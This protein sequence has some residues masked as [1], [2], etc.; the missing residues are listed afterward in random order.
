MDRHLL[1]LSYLWCFVWSACQSTQTYA[2]HD[3]WI[4]KLPNAFSSNAHVQK[5][6][7]FF[8][9]IGTTYDTKIGSVILANV[10]GSANVSANVPRNFTWADGSTNVPSDTFPRGMRC[11]IIHASMA[12]KK[13]TKQLINHRVEHFERTKKGNH[14]PMFWIPKQNTTLSGSATAVPLSNNA[15][16]IGGSVAFPFCVFSW[17]RYFVC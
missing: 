1:S 13:Q 15:P 7:R 2:Y 14:N 16:L 10:V 9:L 8:S 6:C 3:G 5:Y 4:L 12:K 11:F 17:E